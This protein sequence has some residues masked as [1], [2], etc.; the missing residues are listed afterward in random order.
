[1]FGNLTFTYTGYGWVNLTPQDTKYTWMTVYKKTTD[2][3]LVME[4][5]LNPKGDYKQ[6]PSVVDPRYFAKSYKIC[7]EKK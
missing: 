5:S 1:M 4:M 3:K 2:G 7:T 6:S